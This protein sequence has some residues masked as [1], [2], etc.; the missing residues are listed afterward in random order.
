[1][2]CDVPIHR[3]LRSVHLLWHTSPFYPTHKILCFT[4]LFNRP[5]TLKSDCYTTV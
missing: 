1:M 5:D 4:T 2:S 3:S